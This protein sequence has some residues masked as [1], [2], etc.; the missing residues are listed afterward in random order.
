MDHKGPSLHHQES[1]MSIR[2][3]GQITAARLAADPKVFVNSDGSK[4]VHL[5][6]YVDRPYRAQDGTRP[7]DRIQL[8]AFLR[9][10]TEFARTPFAFMHTGDKVALEYELRSSTYADKAT[11]EI[12]YSQVCYITDVELLDSLATTNARLA[13]RLGA[14]QVAD[15]SEPAAHPGQ[16]RT[17]RQKATAAA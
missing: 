11:G 8:E 6:V 2:N 14:A 15:Q 17:T 3:R 12:K 13:Q 7:S 10:E 4:S 1:S 16:R 5:T 9:A